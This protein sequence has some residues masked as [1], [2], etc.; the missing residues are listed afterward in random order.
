MKYSEKLRDPRWQKRRL[1]ILQRD[2]FTCQKCGDGEETLAVHHFFYRKGI[3]PWDYPDS[4][5]L[6][7]CE[8][9][10]AEERETRQQNEVMLLSALSDSGW[11]SGDINGLVFD[12]LEGRVSHP[13][14]FAEQV[15]LDCDVASGVNGGVPK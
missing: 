9:C 12:I 3:E 13:S 1:E 7:L 10:H 11:L 5:L 8:S 2:N 14:R 15:A 6:T 4:A